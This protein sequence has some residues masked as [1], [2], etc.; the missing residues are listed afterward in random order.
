MKREELK[1]KIS[2]EKTLA[3]CSLEK[4]SRVRGGNRSS[5]EQDVRE[6]E[7]PVCVVVTCVGQYEVL[8]MSRVVWEC[9]PKWV[10]N[11]I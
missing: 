7:N 4:C 10:V 3:N 9:S 1:F 8:S 2:K 5:L 11:F 6:G